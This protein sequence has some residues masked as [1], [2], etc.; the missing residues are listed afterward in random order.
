MAMVSRFDARLAVKIIVTISTDRGVS[1]KLLFRIGERRHVFLDVQLFAY[2]L[3]FGVYVSI[4]FGKDI[5]S[6]VQIW[7]E[8]VIVDATQAHTAESGRYVYGN[9]IFIRCLKRFKV[10]V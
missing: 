7:F 4:K 6:A 5:G 3:L 9:A 1:I 10:Y 8:C 2:S